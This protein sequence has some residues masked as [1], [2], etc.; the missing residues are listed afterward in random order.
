LKSEYVFIH[1]NKPKMDES[2]LPEIEAVLKTLI[3]D[4]DMGRLK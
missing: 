1:W 2:K 3:P 4:F